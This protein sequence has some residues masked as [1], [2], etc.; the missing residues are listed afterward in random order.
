MWMNV[1]CALADNGAAAVNANGNQ[2]DI[3]VTP[4]GASQ[5]R[6]MAKQRSLKHFGA[7]MK[8]CDSSSVHLTLSELA[9]QGH[10]ITPITPDRAFEMMERLQN[11]LAKK[12]PCQCCGSTS[13]RRKVC[14]GC[15]LV[16]YCSVECQKMDRK[17][18]R[19]H[20]GAKKSR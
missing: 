13:K 18:H 6:G 4:I 10:R 20:C 11:M 3:N 8:C 14:T 2:G 9:L 17:A 15:H 5:L 19:P 1:I 12:T 7:D 16:G